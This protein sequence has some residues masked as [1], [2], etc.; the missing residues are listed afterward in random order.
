MIIYREQRALHLQ[1]VQRVAKALYEAAHGGGRLGL[2]LLRTL[3]PLPSLA[4]PLPPP[5]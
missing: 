1:R 5:P 4:S 2:H 3:S